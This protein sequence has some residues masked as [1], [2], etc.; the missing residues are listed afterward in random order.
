LQVIFL[1]GNKCDLEAQ[2]NVTYEEA[3]QFADEN[4]LTFLEAS[5]KTGEKVEE[6]FIETAKQIFQNIQDGSFDLDVGESDMQMDEDHPGAGMNDQRQEVQEYVPDE[7]GH[8]EEVDTIDWSSHITK[9]KSLNDTI[10][11]CAHSPGEC[12]FTVMCTFV[13]FTIINLTLPKAAES[14]EFHCLRICKICA[15]TYMTLHLKKCT[16]FLGART[17]SIQSP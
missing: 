8:L 13:A 17:T 3:K 7:S 15:L 11:A 4:G 10:Y 2:R 6:A 1:I 16:C 5:A 14:I 9:I 12:T